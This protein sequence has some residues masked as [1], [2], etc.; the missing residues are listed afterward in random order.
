MLDTSSHCMRIESIIIF[1]CL[2][3]LIIEFETSNDILFI[4]VFGL[5]LFTEQFQM[6][7]F[8]MKDTTADYKCWFLIVINFVV[9][10]L[11]SFYSLLK[12]SISL[13]AIT[14]PLPPQ[15]CYLPLGAPVLLYYCLDDSS[16]TTCFLRFFAVLNLIWFRKWE[17]HFIF[18]TSIFRKIPVIH[19]FI[20]WIRKSQRLHWLPL[21]RLPPNNTTMAFHCYEVWRS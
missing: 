15:I 6:S 8:N 21:Q 13:W 11:I 2:V 20:F 10:K 16:S 1:L 17:N 3:I 9:L 19:V 18:L 4:L 12:G 7:D 14:Q 5:S